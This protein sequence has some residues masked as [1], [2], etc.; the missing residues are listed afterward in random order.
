MLV[1]YLSTDIHYSLAKGKAAYD[2]YLTEGL[3][4]ERRTFHSLF[5]TKDQKEGEK[6]MFYPKLKE[7]RAHHRAVK[8]MSAFAEKRKANFTHS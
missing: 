3:R 8:G 1:R 6:H 2:L 5:A 7:P 4:F